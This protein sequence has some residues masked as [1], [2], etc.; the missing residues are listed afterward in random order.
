MPQE[1]K[2]WVLSQKPTDTPILSGPNATF[3]QQ[4]TTLPALQANQ[5]LLQ[6][7]YLSNDPAQR[8]WIS[9]D[10]NPER[11]YVAPVPVGAPMYA[12]GLGQVVESTSD[13]FAKGDWVQASMGWTQY[14]VLDAGAVNAAPELPGGLGRTHYLG[15][16]GG[17]GLT[18]WFGITEIGRATKDD[19]V[20]VSGAAGATGSMVV[21]IAKKILGCKK[22]VGIAGGEAKC[23]WVEG[24][25][26]DVCVDYKAQGFRE[27]LAKATEGWANVYYD[28]VGGEIL[29]FM[30]T[31]MAKYGRVVACGAVA[32]YNNSKERTTG[33]KNWFEVISM[34]IEIKGFIVLDF[35]HRAGEAIDVFKKAIAEGKLKVEGGEQIVK[36]G[37]DDVPATW[38]KLFEG[39]NTG[40]LIT[41]LQ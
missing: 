4:T 7:V 22:V 15:A 32:E 21:Q 20:V 39:G 19:V 3:K 37:F 28:N 36:A 26:A 9:P 31:R 14:A 41:A 18:A 33:I 1:T 10:I 24:L 6:T 5:V 8:G 12:R 2:Q 27:Q 29:D 35:I 34:R 23:K 16:L 17:T 40:K 38:M 30:L 13:K 11:L 25:G